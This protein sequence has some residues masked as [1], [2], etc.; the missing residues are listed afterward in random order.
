VWQL[1]HHG[2][3]TIQNTTNVND[4]GRLSEE[5]SVY[6]GVLQ[7]ITTSKYYTH[8]NGFTYVLTNFV[9]WIAYYLEAILDKAASIGL[10]QNNFKSDKATRGG[11]L[12]ETKFTGGNSS[13]FVGNIAAILV[14]QFH[15][16]S[17]KKKRTPLMPLIR[18]IVGPISMASI[19][20]VIVRFHLDK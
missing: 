11:T 18:V 16:F 17:V 4:A 5:T 20:M 3:S 12:T 10:A 14:I 2:G 7:V 6:I 8:L 15:G 13:A 9:K 19:G 1:S